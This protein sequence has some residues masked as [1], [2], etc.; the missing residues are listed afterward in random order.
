MRPFVPAVASVIKSL[1]IF[2]MYAYVGTIIII[3]ISKYV[4]YWITASEF[5]NN[6]STLVVSKSAVFNDIKTK[7]D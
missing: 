1:P 3:V 4:L 7:I 2:G 6:D 5:I